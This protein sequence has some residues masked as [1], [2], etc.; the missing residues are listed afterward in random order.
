[1]FPSIKSQSRYKRFHVTRQYTMRYKYATKREASQKLASTHKYIF[2]VENAFNA[3]V[4]YE[5]TLS[6]AIHHFCKVSL[7]QEKVT[8]CCNLPNLTTFPSFCA[9]I[10]EKISNSVIYGGKQRFCCHLLE[11][12]KFSCMHFLQLYC[13]LEPSISPYKYTNHTHIH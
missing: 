4:N 12:F 7:L 3:Y 1:M 8:T 10:Y 13:L 11:T 5:H 6:R 9:Q 2:H